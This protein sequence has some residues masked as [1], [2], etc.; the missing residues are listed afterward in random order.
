MAAPIHIGIGGWDYRSVARHLLSDGPGQDEAAR[1]RR[2]SPHRDRDQRDPLRLQTPESFRTLGRSRSR[3]LQIRGQG[4]ALLHQPQRAGRSG[5]GIANFCAQGFTELGDKLG[6]ILWQFMAHKQFDP[7]DFGAFLKLLPGERDGLA[8]SR[9][10][11]AP[12]ELQASRLRRRWPAMLGWRS[13]SRIS[14]DYPEIADLTA[15]FVYA[16]LQRC[17]EGLRHRLRRYRARPL[18]RPSRRTG[19]PA[20]RPDGLALCRAE[21]A[22]PSRAKLLSSSSPAPRC[23]RRLAAQASD[24]AAVN[25]LFADL[26]TTIFEHMSGLARELQRGQ[27]RPGLSRF[28]LAGRCHRGG[29]RAR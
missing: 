20:R 28:R 13:S 27:P 17:R 5:E 4:V 8:P 15:D 11:G 7:D 16:R 10:R 6:P 18:G 24:R 26:P 2:R 25:P 19:Q 14:D 23:A 9:G 1:V 12:R 3:R 21:V 29:G 22:R